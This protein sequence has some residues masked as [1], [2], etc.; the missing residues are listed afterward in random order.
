MDLQLRGAHVLTAEQLLEQ[1]AVDPELGLSSGEAEE[2]L[3]SM[4]A[5]RLTSRKQRPQWL[6]FLAQFHAPLLYALL[7]TGAVKALVGSL[8][9]AV[10]IWSVTLINAV[11]G[12]VQESR[13]ERSIGAL[14]LAIRS[15][16]EVLRDGRKQRLD[17]QQLVPGDLVFLVAGDRVPADLRLLQVRNLQLDESS[18]TGESLPVAKAIST[19]PEDAPLAE[20]YGMAHAGSFVT[21]GQGRGL[22][23]ATG[24]ATELGDLA[25]SLQRGSVLSTP[26]TRKFA[27]FS[28][29]VLRF[30]LGLSLITALVGLARGRN[31]GEMFDA[32][33]AL[34]VSAIPEELPAI[35]TITLAIGVHR[36]AR[37]NAIIRKL[38]AVEALGSAT[39]ICSDKTGTLTQNRMAVQE[40]Y[41]AGQRLQLEQLWPTG[42]SGAPGT[43]DPLQTN[44]ALRE[45]LLAGLLCSDARPSS[46]EGL[47]G[48]PTETAL[49]AAA[50]RAGFDH[51]EAHRRHPRR[52]ALPFEAELQVMA[53]LHG[54]ERILVKGS[55][56]AVLPRCHGQCGSDG[57]LEA[58][59]PVAIHTAVDSMATRGER[60]LAFAMGQAHPQQASLLHDHIEAHLTFLGLQG[61]ADPPRPEATRAVSACLDAGITVKMITGDHIR[62]AIA[63]A[64]QMGIGHRPE[65]VAIDGRGLAAL[66]PD[67]LVP[68][69]LQTDVFARMAPAQKLELVRS[70]QSSGQIVAM[71]G[72]GVNDAPALR[73][74]DIGIA[75][76]AGGTAVARES[77][78][79][80]LTD[81]NFASIAAAVEEGRGVA[82]NLHRAMA[83]CLP[84]N[85]GESF[86]I[87]ISALLGLDLP[88]TAL[89]VLWLNMVNSLTMSLPLAF[90]PKA[91]GLMTMPPQRPDRPLLNR[92]LLQRL[93]LVSAFS[94]VVIFAMFFWS[95]AR[96]GDQAVARTM[97]VQ[98]LV[99]SRVAYLLSLSEVVQ[100][101]PGNWSRFATALWRSPPLML[102]LAG[103]LLLQVLFSQ[104]RVMNVFFGTAPLTLQQW[105]VCSMA[106]VLMIPVAHA[107]NRL[108]PLVPPAA[109]VATPAA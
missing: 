100:H 63:I 105:M 108:D 34:A 40:L 43:P 54:G 29:T 70:L 26:L 18:L 94:W 55:L 99:L 33:V 88:I 2:R 109:S 61:M 98:T 75:M 107:A 58:L 59:D 103:A 50:Q 72:D 53:T 52:D 67:R 6:Q 23:V 38:P 4:G 31:P 83:F 79:M 62:T 14:A 64:R 97:A 9:E 44:R 3:R 19:D 5:N 89:Q 51:A 90:E 71:T 95:E 30:V 39:V 91:P 81:D 77:A 106:I 84:V 25:A 57:G 17:A 10:V 65:P 7:I 41:A 42:S 36:M 12:F 21:T 86:T 16:I 20:R 74:A 56:E 78:A 93:L 69:A 1:L 68:V 66:P 24:D 96:I 45:L 13:A 76:G 73:Q 101:L 32:A 28:M 48:D 92:P 47:V 49:L 15:D 85:G 8:R 46:Q 60:V 11:I 104:W 22:V 87:L 80:V 102:G 82:L 37:R 27:R 35:V